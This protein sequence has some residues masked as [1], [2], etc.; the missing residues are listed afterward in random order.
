MLKAGEMP[1]PELVAASGRRGTLTP[2]RAMQLGAI[3]VIGMVASGWFWGIPSFGESV[4]GILAPEV[5]VHQAHALLSD[6]GLENS[7]ADSAWGFDVDQGL[8]RRAAPTSDAEWRALLQSEDPPVLY[9][10]YRASPSPMGPWKTSLPGPFMGDV[11]IPED[12]PLTEA[13]M[14]LVQLGPRG[15]FLGLRVVPDTAP[16]SSTRSVQETLATITDAAGLDPSRIERIEWSGIPPMPGDSTIAWRARS[17]HPGSSPREFVATFAGGQLTWARVEGAPKTGIDE[18]IEGSLGRIGL[19]FF[20]FFAGGAVVAGIN[21]RS[22]RWDRRGAARLAIAAFILCF[23]GNLIGSHHT[24]SVIEEIRGL[25]SAVAYASTRALM[26]WL[27][28]IAI[29]PFIRRLH[30]NS[31]VSWSRL[32]AGRVSDPAVGRDILVGLTLF[33]LQALFVVVS[34]WI[35]DLGKLGLPAF[36]FFFGYTPLA[37]APYLASVI[38]YPVV[39]LGTALGFLLVYVVARRTLGRL[40]RAAPLILWIAVFFFI[41]GLYTSLEIRTTL[42][43]AVI[44][45]TASTYVAVRHGLLAFATFIF[46]QQVSTASVITLDPSAW[47]FPPTAILLLLVAAL[48]IFGIMTATD[49]KLIPSRS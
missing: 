36:A 47:Y 15:T 27:L 10:W 35:L 33:S 1:S 42:T 37:T 29:E 2:R 38:R 6:L 20:A 26:T 39:T 40:D 5:L 43:F 11:V 14:S 41:F 24:L 30:P 32:L 22:G 23:A 4:G 9:F 34:T 17:D 28:Y 49:R 7:F 18:E 16:G 3:I 13:G 31:L 48:T 21:I 45:A 46:I 25:F 12:P 44:S 8:V 19:I